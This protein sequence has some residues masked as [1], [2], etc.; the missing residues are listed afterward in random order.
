MAVEWTIATHSAAETQSLGAR[1]A[2]VRVDRDADDVLRERSF[3][4]AARRA[5]SQELEKPEL[6]AATP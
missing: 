4:A 2:E 5:A 3:E 1:L 6:I